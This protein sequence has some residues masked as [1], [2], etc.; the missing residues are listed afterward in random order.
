M[1]TY[2][3]TLLTPA[4]IKKEIYK[5][6]QSLNGFE[7]QMKAKYG[8]FITQSCKELFEYTPAEIRAINIIKK[9]LFSLSLDKLKE[10]AKKIGIDGEQ[11][12][13]ILQEILK[14]TNLSII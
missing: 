12:I 7:N 2:E 4:G 10:R 9:D 13:L 8:T 11:R 6:S 14:Q 3:I 5:D 1:K